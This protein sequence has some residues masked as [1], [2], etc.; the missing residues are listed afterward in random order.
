MV[1][2]TDFLREIRAF[3]RDTPARYEAVVY[4][5]IQ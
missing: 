4:T 2:P 1:L 5:R 3:S